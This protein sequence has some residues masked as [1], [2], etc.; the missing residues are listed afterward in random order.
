MITSLR[1]CTLLGT[2]YIIYGGIKG[3]TERENSA[4]NI[5]FKLL[6]GGG[7]HNHHACMSALIKSDKI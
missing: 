2:L 1:K 4:G 6:F 7:V 3:G 5:G